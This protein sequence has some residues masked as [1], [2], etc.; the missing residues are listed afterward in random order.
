MPDSFSGFS[1]TPSSPCVPCHDIHIQIPLIVY[2]LPLHDDLCE[3]DSPRLRERETRLELRPPRPWFPGGR[4]RCSRLVD[5][6]EGR[7]SGGGRGR[8]GEGDG[9]VG[10]AELGFE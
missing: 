4:E 5:V 10:R 8:E 6:Y 1:C 9:E 2:M 7:G 3:R